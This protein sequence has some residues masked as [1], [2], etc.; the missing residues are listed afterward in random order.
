MKQLKDLK[1]SKRGSDLNPEENADLAPQIVMEDIL[2]DLEAQMGAAEA[3]ELDS[4]D[5]FLKQETFADHKD[6]LVDEDLLVA[7]YPD[8]SMDR[9]RVERELQASHYIMKK[10][11]RGNNETMPKKENSANK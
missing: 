2:S 4:F 1:V 8:A 10:F 6:F 11:L 9:I 5:E 3:N 7:A